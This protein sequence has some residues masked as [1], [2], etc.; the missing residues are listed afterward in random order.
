[1]VSKPQPSLFGMEPSGVHHVEL[2]SDGL[3]N[4]SVKVAGVDLTPHVSYVNLRLD[5]REAPE[6]SIEL[7]PKA[8]MYAG[9]AKVEIAGDVAKAL[10]GLGWTPPRDV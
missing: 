10:I 2:K 5:A 1:M 7:A 4:H 6:V 8:L 3:Y 9:R